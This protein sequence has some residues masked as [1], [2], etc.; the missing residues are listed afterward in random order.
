MTHEE[1]ETRKNN[2]FGNTEKEKYL[3]QRLQV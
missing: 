1:G 3:P 2:D